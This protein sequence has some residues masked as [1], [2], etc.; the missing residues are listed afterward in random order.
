MSLQAFIFRGIGFT[1]NQ[2]RESNIQKIVFRN[3]IV[4]IKPP[5]PSG[6]PPKG[7]ENSGGK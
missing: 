6:T 5:R 2:I 7:G 3:P 4:N 1:V